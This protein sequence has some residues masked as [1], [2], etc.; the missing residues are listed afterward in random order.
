MGGICQQSLKDLWPTLKLIN[1]NS[2][3][4]KKNLK[5]DLFLETFPLLSTFLYINK[6]KNKAT[7][8]FLDTHNLGRKTLFL[9]HC[10]VKHSKN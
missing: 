7:V 1:E 5:S 10:I 3:T 2:S 4:L 6:I 8:F 9:N